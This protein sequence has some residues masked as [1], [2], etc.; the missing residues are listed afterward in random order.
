MVTNHKLDSLF[1]PENLK[2]FARVKTERWSYIKSITIA[3][4]L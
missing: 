2:F 1:R 4:I 3:L